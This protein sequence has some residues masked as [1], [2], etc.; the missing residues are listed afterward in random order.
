M[1]AQPPQ[2]LFEQVPRC[3]ISTVQHLTGSPFAGP[4]HE[5]SCQS[6]E[7]VLQEQ[8]RRLQQCVCE[9]LIK[10]QQLRMLLSQQ[11]NHMAKDPPR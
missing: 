10:N 3:A 1:T 5:Q 7:E 8:L 11:M 2:E 9:L 6:S 4:L